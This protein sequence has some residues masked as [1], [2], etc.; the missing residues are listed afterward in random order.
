VS[1]RVTDRFPLDHV[2]LRTPDFAGTLQVLEERLGL[3]A[4]RTP[5]APQQ[6][7]RIFLNR[8]YLEIRRSDSSPATVQASRFFLR[9]ED[10]S[11][12][13]AALAA[14]GLTSELA[15][16][17][18][19]DGV[20]EDL[21][22]Q[23]PEATALLLV[24]RTEPPEVAMDWPPAQTDASSGLHSLGGVVLGVPDMGH[25]ASFFKKLLGDVAVEE[26]RRDAELGA[27]RLDIAWDGFRLGVV[28]RQER[29]VEAVLLTVNDLEATRR[30]VERRG[31]RAVSRN[32]EGRPELWVK[33]E[34]L[35]GPMRWVLVPKP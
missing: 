13:Q 34:G 6:H 23:D 27:D 22:V 2:S 18:G 28:Q 32:F 11:R 30:W 16:Y 26:P 14:R 21:T 33:E 5:A 9:F 12:A 15:T 24:R 35:P 19:E 25:A 8:S 1:A 7:A 10:G 3:V 17:Q 20:W 4:R 29:N 31:L